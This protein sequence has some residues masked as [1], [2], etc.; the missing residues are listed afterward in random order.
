MSSEVLLYSSLILSVLA[1]TTPAAAA[2]APVTASQVSEDFAA[3]RL[4][5]GFEDSQ[6]PEFLDI[7]NLELK[8]I[9]RLGGINASLYKVPETKSVRDVVDA[10]NAQNDVLWA[11]PDFVRRAYATVDD[12]YRDLQWHLDQVQAD[13]AWDTS[14]GE[15]TIV[16]VIDTGVTNGPLDGLTRLIEGY[17]FVD[18]DRDASDEN[19]HGTH[20]AGTIAAATN[21]GLGVAGLAY[22]AEILPVRV[23]GADGS[24]FTSDVVD[25]INYAVSNGADV[26]NLSL[27]SSFRSESEAA[28]VWAAYEAGVF[29]AAASGNSAG[30]RADYPANHPGAVGVGA[31]DAVYGRAWYSNRGENV[32]L[33]APGGDLGIDTDGDGYGDGVLQE[34]F[35]VDRVGAYVWGYNFFQGTSMATPHVAAAAALLMSEGATSDEA[36]TLLSDTA[37]DLGS[38]GRDNHF[39]A[40]LIQPAAAL[41]GLLDIAPDLDD[42][43]F[44]ADADCDDFDASIYPGAPELCGDGIDQD[45]DGMDEICPAIDEDGDGFT[46]DEDCDDSDPSIFPGAFDTCGDGI[47]QDCDGGDFSCEEPCTVEVTR[48]RYQETS[49]WLGIQATCSEPAATMSVYV[50]GV[51]QT[52]LMYEP[53]RDTYEARGRVPAPEVVEVVSSCGGTAVIERP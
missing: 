37:M 35:S 34:T 48:I 20:V 42:D 36:L 25:G 5:V 46:A 11:E 7:G 49:G 6:G 21:N 27:G 19:G 52:E 12:P 45:C 30:D 10:A 29:V 14:T 47:D 41:E 4:I 22:N 24:G 40:G 26:L 44:D 23:L 38:P 1:L 3:D 32:D 50:D 18:G 33:A 28:A 15:G 43:G 16:A 51:Y 31:I 13:L 53:L 2:D 17:D 39:G 9:R 8:R